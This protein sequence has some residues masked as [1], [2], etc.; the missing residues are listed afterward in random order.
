MVKKQKESSLSEKVSEQHRLNS[1]VVA[2]RNSL[3]NLE[4]YLI[5]HRTVGLTG[6]FKGL[7]KEMEVIL[8]SLEV[9]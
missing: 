8:R 7:R 6:T 1:L 2:I 9:N 3:E 5:D 4:D